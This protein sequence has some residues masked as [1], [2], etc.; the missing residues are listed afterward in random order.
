METENVQ[1]QYSFGN[2]P[3]RGGRALGGLILLGL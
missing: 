3:N 1:Q 2:R